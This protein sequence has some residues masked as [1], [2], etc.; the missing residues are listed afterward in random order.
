M[1]TTSPFPVPKVS[2]YGSAFGL[3]FERYQV[4]DGPPRFIK[5][6]DRPTEVYSVIWNLDRAQF[7]AFSN[8]FRFNLGHG[9][10]SFLTVLD[11]GDHDFDQAEPILRP[12][13][14]H[15]VDAPRFGRNP[16]SAHGWTVSA[17]LEVLIP[18]ETAIRYWPTIDGGFPDALPGDGL[19]GGEHDDLPVDIVDGGQA[20][21]GG[22]A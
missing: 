5:T 11:F 1:T 4:A 8:W 16:T 12:V 9:S 18:P 19:D 14:V 6:R 3:G 21:R 10:R 7:A 2:G 22:E 20:G 17:S 15:F 13:E